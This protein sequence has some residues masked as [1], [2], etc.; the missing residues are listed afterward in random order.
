LLGRFWGKEYLYVVSGWG[1][2]RR[3]VWLSR[4]LLL[5]QGKV[6]CDG[7][8]VGGYGWYVGDFNVDFTGLAGQ[9]RHRERPEGKA[10]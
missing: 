10:R 4:R 1:F 3:R 6:M 8:A 7:V 2:L 5:L 9:Q